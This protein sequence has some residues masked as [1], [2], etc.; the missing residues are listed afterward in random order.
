MLVVHVWQRTARARASVLKSSKNGV[1][2]PSLEKPPDLDPLFDDL[3]HAKSAK[4]L[5]E[6]LETR[7]FELFW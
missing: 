6:R 3:T 4:E 1:H 7:I 2:I 5:K